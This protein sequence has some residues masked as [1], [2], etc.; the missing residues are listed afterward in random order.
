MLLAETVAMPNVGTL[1]TELA[2]P[3]LPAAPNLPTLPPFD[4]SRSNFYGS[5]GKLFGSLA[6]VSSNFVVTNYSITG[7]AYISIRLENEA[8][9]EVEVERV[10]IIGLERADASSQAPTRK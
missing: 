2:L 1:P 7:R 6:P 8:L 5:V 3:T 10:D 4:V 9:S